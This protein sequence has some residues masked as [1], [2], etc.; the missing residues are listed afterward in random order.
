MYIALKSL[1][2][3]NQSASVRTILA[4]WFENVPYTAFETVPE[5]KNTIKKVGIFA[6]Q[7]SKLTCELQNFRIKISKN[8]TAPSLLGSRGSTP[9]PGLL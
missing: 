3:R 2:L 4:I 5:R 8:K 7:K 1:L 6:R 9:L